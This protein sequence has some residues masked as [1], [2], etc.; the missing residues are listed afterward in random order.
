MKQFL[1]IPQFRRWYFLPISIPERAF[2]IRTKVF[3]IVPF[4]S[5]FIVF[6]FTFYFLT[7][8]FIYSSPHSD[9]PNDPQN[10]PAGAGPTFAISAFSEIL[11]QFSL[12]TCSWIYREYP[13]MFLIISHHFQF[14]MPHH[15]M[16]ASEFYC[17]IKFP[18]DIQT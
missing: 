11:T 1:N 16:V 6:D 7:V 13:M 4:I 17:N 5:E 18:Y 2:A 12:S 10:P 8:G 3:R 9:L 14:A 15:E